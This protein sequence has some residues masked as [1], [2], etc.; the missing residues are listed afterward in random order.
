MD[1]NQQGLPEALPNNRTK[2]PLDFAGVEAWKA[3]LAA[4]CIPNERHVR[5]VTAGTLL[6]GRSDRGV[7][8]NWIGLSE[9]AW[10]GVIRLPAACWIHAERPLI[11]RVPHHDAP[12]AVRET[13]GGQLGE[14]YKALKTY[15]LN[16]D[17][18]QKP[19]REARFDT[20]VDQRTGYPHVHQVLQ[21]MRAMKVDMLRVLE[22]PDIPRHNNAAE[23]DMRAFVQRR[24]SSGGTRSAAG[25]RCRDTFASLKK[26]GRKVGVCFGD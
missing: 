23:S 2:G 9:G 14:W 12:R 24:T 22:H 19:L 3:G 7:S 13:I 4:L 6:G 21:S 26:T 5:I 11:K 8:P 17:P 15:T 1:W 20:W 25:R 18:A 10:Q 16:A